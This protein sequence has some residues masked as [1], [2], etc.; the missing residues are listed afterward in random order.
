ML[1]NLI[2]SKFLFS[3]FLFSTVCTTL[4]PPLQEI[5]G[6]EGIRCAIPDDLNLPVI[7]YSS[8]WH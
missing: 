4:S 8:P 6:A 3:V 1:Y 5:L 7:A 2:M